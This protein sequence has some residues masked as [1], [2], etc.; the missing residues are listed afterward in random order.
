MATI[1]TLSAKV[2]ADGSAFYKTMDIVDKRMK[3]TEKNSEKLE[4]VAGKMKIL[5]AALAAFAAGQFIADTIKGVVDDLKLSRKIGEDIQSIEA[6]KIALSGVGAPAEKAGE[7]LQRLG[8]GIANASV[9]LDPALEDSLKRIGLQSSKLAQLRPYD[10]LQRISAAIGGI[11]DPT[12]RAAV[13]TQ[14]FSEHASDLLPILAQGNEAFDKAAISLNKI[15]G[16]IKNAEAASL[17]K[18]VQQAEKFQTQLKIAAARII[19]DIIPFIQGMVEQLT[20]AFAAGHDLTDIMKAVAFGIGTVITVI[21]ELVRLVKILVNLFG[22]G[23]LGIV[24]AVVRGLQEIFKQAAMLPSELG[25]DEFQKGAI[26]LSH[27][28]HSIKSEM[29]DLAKTTMKNVDEIGSDFSRL[30]KLGKQM[31]SGVSTSVDKVQDKIMNAGGSVHIADKFGELFKR[32]RDVTNEFQT[33][34]QKYQSRIQ[35]LN[36]MISKGAISWDVYSRAAADAVSQLE[37]AHELN[38][39][40]APKAILKNT[41]EAA[42]AI[43]QNSLREARYREK[44][45]DRVVRVLEQSKEIEKKQLDQF[46]KVADAAKNTKIVNF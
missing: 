38:S 45:E 40:S 11:D 37:K 10:Q 2:T 31:A 24:Y 4:A 26:A 25:G 32:G 21:T 22:M 6:F 20:R 13:A 23:L 46:K 43:N 44:P 9:G 7:I 16:G 41:S 12:K 8:Q 17:E 33:P 1:A 28:S 3:K 27:A 29:K 34:L 42:S 5:L 14:I 30:D 18:L 35:E 39:L 15:G 36:A 19:I